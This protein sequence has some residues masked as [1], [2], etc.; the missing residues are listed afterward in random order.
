MAER[1]AAAARPTAHIATAATITAAP[2][3]D[4]EA[5][6][7]VAAADAQP[8]IGPAAAPIA[9]EA[10]GSPQSGAPSTALS[11]ALALLAAVALLSGALCAARALSTRP[12]WKERAMAGGSDGAL[13]TW[14][15]AGA[16]YDALAADAEDEEQRAVTRERAA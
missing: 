11:S 13:L 4:V 7:A 8:H 3:E 5:V 2:R 10:A 16:G 6:E 1:T 9:S 14:T 12:W 15:A